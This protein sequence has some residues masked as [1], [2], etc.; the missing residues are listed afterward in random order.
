MIF[1]MGEK[2]IMDDFFTM[3]EKMNDN[4]KIHP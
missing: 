3:D 1:M 2:K 4:N